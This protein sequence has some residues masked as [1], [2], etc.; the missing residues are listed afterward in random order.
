MKKTFVF[1]TSVVGVMKMGNTAPRAEIE[2]TSLASRAS[3]LP[4]TP[5][6]FPDVTPIPMLTCLCSS[7]PQTLVQTLVSFLYST[8]T[9]IDHRWT[10]WPNCRLAV[11]KVCS[12][13]SSWTNDLQY[14]VSG[15]NRIEHELAQ[16]E[17][18]LIKWE[19]GSRCQWPSLAEGQHCL[20][21]C[22]F[23]P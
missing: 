3:V 6:R 5:C 19:M 11:W 20:F 13:I 21:V 18:N 7:M 2:S 10:L 9:H 14:L 1:N 16:Y 23:T 8:H 12:S 22:C 15:M 17:D 4:F